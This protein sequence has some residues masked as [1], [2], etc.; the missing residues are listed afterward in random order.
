VGAH[1]DLGELTPQLRFMPSVEVGFGD[2][3]TTVALNG[4]LAWMFR[5]V[6]LNLPENAGIWRPY[7]GG[8]LALVYVDRDLPPRSRADSTD[9]DLGI[10]VLGGL[11]KRL[12]S[13]RR[14]F[15]ELKIGLS[16]APDFKLTAGITF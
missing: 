12:K 13:S 11:E 4:E 8:G 14:F 5:N 16:D 9:T 6:Q 1:L 7:L 2:D 3:Q 10:S 15:T